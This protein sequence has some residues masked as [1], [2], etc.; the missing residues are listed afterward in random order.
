[1]QANTPLVILNLVL[2]AACASA[3]VAVSVA[4]WLDVRE[5]RRWR[6]MVPPCWPPPGVDLVDVVPDAHET[7]A[8]P[9]G[10]ADA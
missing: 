4:A 8:I 3:V 7:Q 1:M 6:A 2:G 5:R 9:T 10:R